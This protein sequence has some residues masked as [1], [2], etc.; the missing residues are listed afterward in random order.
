MNDFNLNAS[1]PKNC[2]FTKFNLE[3]TVF[4]EVS[5]DFSLPDYV[6]EVRR[7]LFAKA[8]VLPESK[9]ISEGSGA[10]SLE[11]GGTV[12]YAIIYVDDEGKLC[13]TPLSSSFEEKTSLLSHPNT[14]FVDTCV[15]NLSLRVA[16]PRKLSL[17]TRLKSKIYSFEENEY[18]ENIK[19][20]SSAEELY[21]ERLGKSV[22][23]LG[24]KS[25]SMQ[26]IGISEKFDTPSGKNLVPVWCDADMCV[27]NSTVKS[28]C[29]EVSCDVHIKCLCE[30]EG[31][32]MTLEKT[33]PL[34]EDVECDGVSDKDSVR[35][36]GR[37]VSLTIS[38][39]ENAES[40]SLFF[41]VRC[42]IECDV[43]GNYENDVTCDCFS[44]KCEV[45]TTYK[46]MDVFSSVC[47]QNRSF[48]LNE[49]I[50]RKSKDMAD[51]IDISL[52]PV[53]EKTEN[54][55]GKVSF[56]G[57]LKANIIGK[58]V[59]DENARWEYVC[60]SYEIPF[61]Y[62]TDI[63]ADKEIFTRVSA[64]AFNC[65]SRLDE[66]KILL[67][68]EIYICY[69]AIAKESIKILDSAQLKTENSFDEDEACIRIF[70]PKS[71]D[72]LW[73]IAKKYHTRTKDILE[74]NSLEDVSLNGVDHI[75][76]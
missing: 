73:D 58:S 17:K 69:S 22:S 5:E 71:G 20:R 56:L 66:D 72:T 26:N 68:T 41:D 19:P 57:N 47:A 37:C 49:S 8:S 32:I 21:I 50:R 4:T 60:E 24:V 76:I 27:K 75:I 11:F 36:I 33:I 23:S 74:Q 59:P 61:K 64:N 48:S 70:F 67:N 18:S 35:A 28:N 2:N 30:C 34:Y 9:F 63:P 54:K 51:I 55:N 38:S 25:A 39:E 52:S 10:S 62:D 7:V 6:P 46:T 53:V 13:S 44:T 29:I 40:S 14:V 3:N 31:E 12:T 1:S 43:Y 45:E 15:D 42:E 65:S 16:A